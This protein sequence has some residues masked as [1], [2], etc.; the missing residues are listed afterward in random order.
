[1]KY[2]K[3][4]NFLFNLF[5]ITTDY[6]GNVLRTIVIVF[7]RQKQEDSASFLCPLLVGCSRYQTQRRS[8]KLCMR[9]LEIHHDVM[10][11]QISLSLYR[12]VHSFQPFISTIFTIAFYK[13]MILVKMFMGT[14]FRFRKRF[15]GL[16]LRAIYPQTFI[17][18][19]PHLS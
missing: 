13:R 6:K 9:V 2:Y 16:E 19:I 14:F 17:K 18:L 7:N 1:M 5:V 8:D 10:H 11:M 4:Q 3:N 15:T 12:F